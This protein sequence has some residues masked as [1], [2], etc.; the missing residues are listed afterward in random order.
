MSVSNELEARVEQ[1]E[2]TVEHLRDQV[3]QLA[4]S[5]VTDP[6]AAYYAWL[7]E[8]GV[9]QEERTLAENLLVALGEARSGV[10][11]D[12][13]LMRWLEAHVDDAVVALL[14]Q[15]EPPDVEELLGGALNWPTAQIAAMR[16][17]MTRQGVF[18]AALG[19]PG[20]TG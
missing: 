6:G 19:R 10:E 11:P 16:E 14:R 5:K 9:E 18:M 20:A 8:S 7:V 4:V 3:L 1:L 2:A 13:H 12:P 17:A 15:A